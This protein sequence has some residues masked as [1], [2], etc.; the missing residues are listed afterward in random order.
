MIV[1]TEEMFDTI[2]V[3]AGPAALSAAVFTARANLK[4]LVIGE[5]K[6]SLLTS[7]ASIGN[8]IDT[9]EMNGVEWLERGIGQIK[10][11]GAQF[12]EGEVVHVEKRNE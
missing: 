2:I 11:Y 3:G 10:K 6:K 4:T 8:Y 12:I 5:P 9:D 1:M 7:A